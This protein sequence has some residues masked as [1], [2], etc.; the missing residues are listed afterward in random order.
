M[1]R[2]VDI[3]FLSLTWGNI[4]LI[5]AGLAFIYLAIAKK[6]EPY[7]LLPIGAG[8]ILANLPG[9][10]LL[11][12]PQEVPGEYGSA[13]ILGI[14]I[15]YGLLRYTI[16]P[17][18]IFIGLGAM[19]D[20]KPLIA[21]PRLFLLGAAAQIGIFV[22]FLGALLL[23]HFGVADFGLKEAASIAIIGGADGPTTIFTTSQLAPD[24]MGIT[25]V[26]AYSYMA[27]VALIQPPIIRALTSKKERQTYMKPEVRKI[28]KREELL[29]PLICLLLII[30]LVPRSAPLVGMFMVGNLFRVSG[31]VERLSDTAQNALINIVTILLM[32]CIGASMPA[33]LVMRPETLMVLGLGLVAFACGTAGGVLI[34]KLMKLV[35]KEPF[36]PI[37][38]AAGVSAVPMAARVAH[39]IGQTENP[40]NF[41]IMH[42]MGPNVAGV[43][44]S[45]VV[46][47]VFLTAL[48]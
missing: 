2:F 19:T 4:I 28:S 29:F 48:G 22:A 10:G 21:N 20:F 39:H 8:L 15:E 38:G 17:I 18:L 45:A 14:F 25:A 36:N 32:L 27:M 26:T 5:C 3:G 40:R 16:L 37:I 42:A 35:S 23:G 34:G 1:L 43:I 6:W 7:E 41:L 31:V 30:L 24:L 47:G 13:G 11:I 44:G 12:Q 46:A 9:T 33:E